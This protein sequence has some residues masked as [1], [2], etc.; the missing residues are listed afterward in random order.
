MTNYAFLIVGDPVPQPRPKVSTIG[1]KPRA[2]Y[3][4]DH[5]IHG[6]KQAVKDQAREHRPDVL[7]ADPVRVRL[8]FHLRRPQN[9][10]R[11]KDPDGPVWHTKQ[12]AD[13]DNLAK[14]VLDALTDDG[15]WNDDGQVAALEVVKFYVEKDGE[16]H[17]AVSIEELPC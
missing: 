11:K 12:N 10:C 3:P 2:Y 5:P 16:P 13:A 7:I 14:G 4:A 6:W 1:G 8:A 17:V 9:L 15:W